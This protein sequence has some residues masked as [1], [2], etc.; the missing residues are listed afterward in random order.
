MNFMDSAK[1][2]DR[3]PL[4]IFGENAYFDNTK[5]DWARLE[6][7]SEPKKTLEEVKKEA[8]SFVDSETIAKRAAKTKREAV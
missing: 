3:N 8:Y 7:Y 6:G 5:E 4:G 2:N 1:A